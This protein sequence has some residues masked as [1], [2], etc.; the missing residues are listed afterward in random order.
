MVM[1]RANPGLDP[2][3][4]ANTYVRKKTCQTSRFVGYWAIK[5]PD[6]NSWAL[7]VGGAAWM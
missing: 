6:E 7:V 1:E 3:E 2:A 4:M 5:N